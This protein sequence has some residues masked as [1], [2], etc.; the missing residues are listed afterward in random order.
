[1]FDQ[2]PCVAHTPTTWATICA[3]TFLFKCP[4]CMVCCVCLVCRLVPVIQWGAAGA[5]HFLHPWLLP[6]PHSPSPPLSAGEGP[7]R[8][9]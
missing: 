9:G 8:R 7:F 5:P 1:M 6:V 3:S 2:Y 4:M